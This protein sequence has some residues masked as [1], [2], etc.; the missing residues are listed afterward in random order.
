FLTDLTA[1]YP[2]AADLTDWLPGGVL[3]SAAQ[4]AG[5]P[6]TSLPRQAGTG[7]PPAPSAA[8]APAARPADLMAA[9]AGEPGLAD[10]MAP[11]AEPAAG[12]GISRRLRAAAREHGTARPVLSGTAAGRPQEA[13]PV[14]GARRHRRG[15]G[16]SGD[17]R[18]RHLA[19][20]ALVRQPD[21]TGNDQREPEP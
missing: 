9:S 13:A 1:A 5:M 15:G 18:A 3:E 12:P 16:R 6:D 21:G 20:P 11:P 2:S 8:G 19:E 10:A 7:T 17:R 14:A 4:R